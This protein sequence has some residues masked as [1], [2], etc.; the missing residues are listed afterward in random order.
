MSSQSDAIV[1]SACGYVGVHGAGGEAASAPAVRREIAGIVHRRRPRRSAVAGHVHREHVEAGAA[2]DTPSSCSPDRRVEGDFGRRA[3]AVDEQHDAIGRRRAARHHPGQ[4]ALAH[5]EL[6]RLSGDRR[7]R[8]LHADEV[9]DRQQPVAVVGASSTRGTNDRDERR[10]ATSD[11]R[12]A[13]SLQAL[14]A[15]RTEPADSI[16]VSRS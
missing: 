14:D 7:H 15:L 9:I 5:V 1:V 6:R 13:P 2:P 4:H 12:I 11:T 3:G 8:R 16:N 10:L